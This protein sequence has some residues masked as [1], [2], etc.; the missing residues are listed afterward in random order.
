MLA[1]SGKNVYTITVSDNRTSDAGNKSK[2]GAVRRDMQMGGLC[3][4]G[5][6]E[7][8]QAGNR[9]ALSGVALC[10]AGL[11]VHLYISGLD[12]RGSCLAE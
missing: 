8:C 4:A 7:S 5:R 3:A 12:R 10:D 1:F 6:R 9:A 11:S 2:A